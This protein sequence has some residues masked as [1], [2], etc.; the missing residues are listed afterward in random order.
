VVAA[1]IKSSFIVVFPWN[2]LARREGDHRAPVDLPW[3]LGTRQQRLDERLIS[4]GV[5]TNDPL[6]STL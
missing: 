2:E 4:F 1:N 6:Y 5:P 3:P